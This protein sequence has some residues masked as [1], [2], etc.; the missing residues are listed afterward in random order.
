M[1]STHNCLYKFSRRRFIQTSAI[2]GVAAFAPV[3]LLAGTSTAGQEIKQLQ[4][5]DDLK[6]NISKAMAIPK[7]AQSM[8]GPYPGVVSEIH[9]SGA[10]NV[11]KRNEE[12]VALMLAAGMKDLTGAKDERDAW[13]AFFSP[14][15]YIGLKVNPVGGQIS[16]TS[17]TVTKAIIASLEAIGVPRKNIVFW[18]HY[19]DDMFRSGYND[20][21]FPGIGLE[22]H[23]RFETKGDK[24]IPRGEDEL[25]MNVF[26]E[27]DYSLPD[28]KNWI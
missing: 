1:K 21:V 12:I 23:H 7:T 2:A 18:D 28:E 25:D 20:K 11:G 17:F 15:D 5:P 22:C 8:P 9:H 6:T 13:S 27:A 10:T 4:N 24:K 16:G 14:Q 26:Y 3:R 19:Y